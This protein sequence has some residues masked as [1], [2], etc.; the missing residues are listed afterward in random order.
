[1]IVG[2]QVNK[3]SMVRFSNLHFGQSGGNKFVIRYECVSF[4]WPILSL[5]IAISSWRDCQLDEDKGE[6][7]FLICLNL[8]VWGTLGQNLNHCLLYYYYCL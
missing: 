7:S 5:L 1:V 8:F 4:E 3:C 6:G 2:G